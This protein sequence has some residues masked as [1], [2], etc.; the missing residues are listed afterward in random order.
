MIEASRLRA[1]SPAGDSSAD[2]AGRA[3]T[4]GTVVVDAVVVDASVAFGWFAAV[5]GSEQA[6]QLLEASPPL[7]LI[8]PDLVLIE[9][10]NAG[11]RS[12]RAGAITA[13]QLEGIAELAPG[14]FSEFVPAASL[15]AAAHRWCIQLDHPA[16]DCLYLALAERE[17][18]TL[19]TQ[20]QRLLQK[21]KP[22]PAARGL[23]LPLQAWRP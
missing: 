20:D 12:L 21:L 4:G 16:Y 11:W 9:L 15:L 5:P 17:G 6:V 18:A 1:S 23:A 19:I 8:A 14:L 7:R 22:T 2:A 13:E 10:L 3:L